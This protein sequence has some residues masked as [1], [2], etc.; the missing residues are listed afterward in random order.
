[1]HPPPNK[2]TT[3][4]V[5]KKDKQ[6]IRSTKRS[7]SLWEIVDSQ[8]QQT[9]GSQTNS[10]GTS[11]KIARKS[12]MS[13]TPPKPIQ[14]NSKKPTIVKVNI[15]HKDQIPIWMHDF[16]EKVID[17]PGDGHC[18]FQ[19]VAVLRNLSVDDHQIVWYNLY[20]ELVDVEN[21]CYRRMINGYKRYKEVSDALSYGGIGN[22][23]RHKWM[24]M[25]DMGFII[26][27]KFNQ[28]VVVLSIAKSET[29]FPLCGPPPPPSID[30]L[31]CLAYV[32]DNHFMPLDLKDGCLIPPTCGL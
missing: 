20:K 28:A 25:P 13:P 26:A 22:A 17:V 18:G 10:T 16:I 31:M 8:E 19:A 2:A 9:Q 14:K 6:S 21:A 24:T 7:P 11:R 27:Q 29:Y 5:S 1:M 23:P 4:G 30:L 15:P 32:N 12:N 3:K